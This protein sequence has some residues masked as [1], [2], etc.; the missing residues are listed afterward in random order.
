MEGFFSGTVII[1]YVLS[2]YAAEYVFVAACLLPALCGGALM[3][4]LRFGGAGGMIAAWRRSKAF[5]RAGVVAAC[6]RGRFYARCV[7]GASPAFRAAYALFLEG[8]I[9][10]AELSRTGIRSASAYKGS[11]SFC[12][13]GMGVIAALLVF[14]TFYFAVPI[15]ETML[16]T[17][18][19]AFHGAVATVSFRFLSYGYFVRAE[20]AA[21]RF[22]SSLDRLL[23]REKPEG[24]GTP[25]F[26]KGLEP[27]ARAESVVPSQGTGVRRSAPEPPKE[28]AALV[29][30]RRLLR[31]LDSAPKTT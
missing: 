24:D 22:S 9:S 21:A 28:D 18:V 10:A 8:K 6:D 4:S 23:L 15:G 14:L 16:R 25:S 29:D 31:E 11:L 13:A 7:K 20:K 12:V 5:R 19:C 30:L 1:L 3:L 27:L 2:R 26:E 17:A